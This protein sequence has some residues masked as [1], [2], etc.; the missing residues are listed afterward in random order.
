ML[1]A[2]TAAAATSVAPPP[3]PQ[4]QQ[5]QQ[6]QL[7]LQVKGSHMAIDG[8]SRTAAQHSTRQGHRWCV[9]NSST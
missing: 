3:P 2:P 7:Q 9:Q 8:A 4:Q 5:Q 1:K 6:L